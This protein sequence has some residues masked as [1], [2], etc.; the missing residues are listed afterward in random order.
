MGGDKNIA[1]YVVCEAACMKHDSPSPNRPTLTSSA[2]N[3]SMDICA[4]WATDDSVALTTRVCDKGGGL[5][6][7]FASSVS[8]QPICVESR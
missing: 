2:S 6:M 3:A 1:K 4:F 7:R 8:T 5:A